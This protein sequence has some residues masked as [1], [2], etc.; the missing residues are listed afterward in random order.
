M[1]NFQVIACAEAAGCWDWVTRQLTAEHQRA[2]ELVLV[3]CSRVRVQKTPNLLPVHWWEKLVLEVNSRLP[4]SKDGSWILVQGSQIWYQITGWGW[5]DVVH[6]TVGYGVQ[7]V[8]KLLFGLPVIR[9]STQ[10]AYCGQAG[11]TG[12]RIVVFLHLVCPWCMRL[13]P[14]LEQSS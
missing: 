7:D 3:T 11:S 8:L 2:Q 12:Y 10:M 6:D 1:I 5:G 14:R 4:A 9:A 13:V